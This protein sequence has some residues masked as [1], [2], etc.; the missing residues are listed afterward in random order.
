MSRAHAFS[1]DPKKR[2]IGCDPD[3]M[4]TAKYISL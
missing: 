3:N 1:E 2:N 4:P